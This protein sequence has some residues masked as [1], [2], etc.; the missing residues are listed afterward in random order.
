MEL[1]LDNNLGNQIALS[2]ETWKSLIKKYVDIE[3]LQSPQTL[4]RTRDLTFETVK[5]VE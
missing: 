3:L 1:I 2:L 4:L 5:I